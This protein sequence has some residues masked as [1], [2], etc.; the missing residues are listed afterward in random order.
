LRTILFVIPAILLEVLPLRADTVYLKNGRTIEGFVLEENPESILLD[1]GFGKVGL[2]RSEIE[3]FSRSNENDSE[4]LRDKWL[5]QKAASLEREKEAKLKEV[6]APKPAPKYVTIVDEHGQI[7]VEA[8]LNRKVKASLFLDTGASLMLIKESVAK[9]L[10]LDAAALKEDMKL[11]LADGRESIAKHAVLSSVSVQGVEAQNV[12]VAILS[13]D[14]KDPALKDGLL[15]MTY[16][17]NFNFKIDQKNK[18]LI[19]E[20]F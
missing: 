2:K 13:A 5:R 17:K 12:D 8:L 18:K 19:L 4:R 20:K 6:S 1:V 7:V 16:L 15:G 11:K 10:G 9:Q 3:S 14:I